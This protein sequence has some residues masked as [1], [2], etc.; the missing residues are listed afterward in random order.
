VKPL[1]GSRTIR[2]RTANIILRPGERFDGQ[3]NL[4]VGDRQ[5]NAYPQMESI[6]ITCPED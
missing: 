4:D 5:Q 3:F 6:E 2:A 1:I